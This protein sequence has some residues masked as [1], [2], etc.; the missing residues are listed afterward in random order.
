MTIKST[1]ALLLIIVIVTTVSYSQDTYP[2]LDSTKVAKINRAFNKAVYCD[3]VVPVYEDLICKK[4]SIIFNQ[5]YNIDNYK[6]IVVIKD[7][8]IRKERR[9]K[10]RNKLYLLI[11]FVAGLL[12]SV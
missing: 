5:N 9:A 11:G 4:D 2:C 10:R 6:S 7:K 3:S 8:V 12:I 1:I